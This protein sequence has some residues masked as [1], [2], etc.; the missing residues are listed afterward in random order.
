MPLS[1][2]AVAA[3]LQGSVSATPAGHSFDWGDRP[4]A[5]GS[6]P[7]EYRGVGDLGRYRDTDDLWRYRHNDDYW[8]HDSYRNRHCGERL[9]WDWDRYQQHCNHHSHQWDCY[10]YWRH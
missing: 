9:G 4:F 6:S 8:R 5:Q 7:F 10:P 2:E 3:P 1:V